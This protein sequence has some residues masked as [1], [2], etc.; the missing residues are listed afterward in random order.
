MLP[1]RSED[2]GNYVLLDAHHGPAVLL[3]CSRPVPEPL[4]GTWQPSAADIKALEANL[5]RIQQLASDAFVK[6][7]RKYYRQYVGVIIGNRKLIYINAFAIPPID[8]NERERPWREQPIFTCDGGRLYWGA[9]YDPET[10][11]FS[12]LAFNGEA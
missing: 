9:V 5:P 2:P 12:D 11:L 10:N 4:R 6:D 7:V 8:G 1:A 3:Q